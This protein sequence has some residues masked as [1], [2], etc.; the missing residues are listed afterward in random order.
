MVRASA[1]SLEDLA[2]DYPYVRLADLISLTFCVGWT[3]PQRFE[4]Y[5]VSRLASR[6]AVTPEIFAGKTIPIAVPVIE[7]PNQPY[8]SNA[9]LHAA[10]ADGRA[11]VL[12]GEVCGC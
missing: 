7:I 10:I 6:I 8:S 5:T 12:N 1:L 4:D 9:R 11:G 2:T 3:E